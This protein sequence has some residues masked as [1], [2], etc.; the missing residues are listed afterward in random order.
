MTLQKART[1]SVP[2]EALNLYALL[3]SAGVK[4]GAAGDVPDLAAFGTAVR[5]GLEESFA[6]RRRLHGRWAQDL[7][8][9]VVRAE[10][11]IHIMRPGLFVDQATGA[12]RVFACGTGRGRQVA[13]A[14]P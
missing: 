1:P 9:A 5:A 12:K 14:L 7:S 4:P 11:L 3:S 6:N 2:I 10:N 13:A 8:Q